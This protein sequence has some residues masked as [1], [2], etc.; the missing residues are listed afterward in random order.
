MVF[1]DKPPNEP[2]V[3]IERINTSGWL[4]WLVMRILSPSNEPKLNGEV[5]SIANIATLLPWFTSLSIMALTSVLLP[6]PGGPVIPI[7]GVFLVNCK[8]FSNSSAPSRSFSTTVSAR[9]TERW[10]L[11]LGCML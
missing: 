6:A 4:K 2:R 11:Q 8:L 7:T 5:G 10:S 3:A 1:A 9:A